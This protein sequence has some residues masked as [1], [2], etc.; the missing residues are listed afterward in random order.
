M[1]KLWRHQQY[2]LGHSGCPA[3]L[4]RSQATSP[5]VGTK[6]SA[7][8]DSRTIL[9]ETLAEC[10]GD[11]HHVEAMPSP[12]SSLSTRKPSLSFHCL[13]GGADGAAPHAGL[14]WDGR[15][16]FYG[17]AAE[18]GYTG[19]TCYNLAGFPAQ[20]CGTVFRLNRSGSSWAFSTLYEFRGG[21]VDGNLPDRAL[22]PSGRVS[23]SLCRHNL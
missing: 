17:T 10:F 23:G 2:C 18:G 9:N 5:V 6:R 7:Y 16:N 19:T 20:G 1:N 13:T 3:T 14:A 21:T 12:V 4:S 15:S 8:H 22:S 11:S